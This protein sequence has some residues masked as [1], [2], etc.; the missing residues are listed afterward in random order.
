MQKTFL[1]LVLMV[2][3]TILT[4]TSAQ[5][6]YSGPEITTSKSM[7][8]GCIFWGAA[9]V[10][11]SYEGYAYVYYTLDGSSPYD[12]DTRILYTQ[13]FYINESCTVKAIGI[14]LDGNATQVVEHVFD[15]RG[16]FSG[17]R[18]SGDTLFI[19]NTQVTLYDYATNC[20]VYYTLDG[21]MPSKSST[22]YTEPFTIDK[23]CT[24]K[25]IMYEYDIYP[26]EISSKDFVK[27]FNLKFLGSKTAVIKYER[28][29][30]IYKPAVVTISCDYPDAVIY[31]TTDGTD[32][33]DQSTIYTDTLSFLNSCTLKAIAY[34]SAS[35]SVSKV[36]TWTITLEEWFSSYTDY[37]VFVYINGN[38]P[39]FNSTEVTITPSAYADKLNTYYTLDGSDPADESS[40]R[41]EYTGPF[42]I[43]STC[44]VRAVVF[45]KEDGKSKGSESKQFIS[46][47]DGYEYDFTVIEGVTPFTESTEVTISSAKQ[48]TS[49]VFY[50][51]L[52]GTTPTHSSL[53]Y[54]A[55]FTITESCTVNAIGVDEN[56]NDIPMASMYFEKDASTGINTVNLTTS[57]VYK[58]IKDGQIIIVKGDKRYNIMGQAVK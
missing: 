47:N 45:D 20:P 16:E 24:V 55:P 26:T 54:T 18:I 22:L 9:D 14:D 36:I 51:T 11:I 43:N 39:F 12:S 10:T 34:D 6:T 1:L 57:K 17:P 42:T 33:T 28:D 15:K 37:A 7:I 38:T 29:T 8:N 19:G 32:P 44:L 49:Y 56:G 30:T 2:L 3:S 13:T 53:E 41:M 50:Y 52:D 27:D 23:S 25:A 46:Y 31:Y 48:S 21:S 40:T 4:P 5:T 58:T 35:G